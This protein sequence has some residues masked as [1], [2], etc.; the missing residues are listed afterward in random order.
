MTAVCNDSM[1]MLADINVACRLNCSILYRNNH[2][3]TFTRRSRLKQERHNNE[4]GQAH[5]G[6]GVTVGDYNGDGQLDILRRIWPMTP[7]N[8]I[9]RN[10][11]R[12]F[13]EEAIARSKAFDHT[14]YVQWG[15]GRCTSIYD[16]WPD[17]FTVHR[18]TSTRGERYFTDYPACRST[19]LVFRNLGN[20]RFKD[21]T[22]QC[23]PGVLT[24]HSSRGVS[25]GV[26]RQRRRC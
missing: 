3:G 22:T 4:D 26:F 14:R 17:I 5:A 25:F 12:G 11:G 18:A 10:S 13:F 23:G 21:F 2:D 15:T 6:M 1:T 9:S 20:G 16:G 8:S 7:A 19:R 24:P